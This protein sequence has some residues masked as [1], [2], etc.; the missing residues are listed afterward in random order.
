MPRKPDWLEV[1]VCACFPPKVHGRHPDA[2]VPDL[3]CDVSKQQVA[4][5]SFAARMLDFETR[6]VRVES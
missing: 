3:L 5:L 1:T 2:A 6:E 4:R